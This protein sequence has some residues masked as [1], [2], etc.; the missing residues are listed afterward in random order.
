[1]RVAAASVTWADAAR[2]A[3]FERWIAAIGPRHDIDPDS[4]APASADASF[5]RY[6]R[7]DCEGGGGGNGGGGPRSLIIM[8]APPRFEDVRPFVRVARLIRSAGLHAPQVIEADE[9]QGF[10]LLEDLGQNLYLDALSSAA[11]AEVERLMRDALS[12]LVRLQQGVPAA[13]LPRYEAA[14]IAAELALF[15]EWC[16]QREFGI[17]WGRA[18]QGAW[19]G[20]CRLIIDSALAEPVVAVHSDFMPRNLMVCKAGAN[21]IS[22]AQLGGFIEALLVEP[23]AV[24]AVAIQQ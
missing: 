12:A 5:R 8:D 19:Q 1:M 24:A 17:H 20:L 18:E 7:V 11:P 15:P 13:A 21:A 6:L 23:N 4:L 9:A 14:Q 22:S 10:L 3:A 2:Q 16:V